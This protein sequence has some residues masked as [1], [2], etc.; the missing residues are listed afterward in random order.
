MAA[1]VTET[2]STTASSITGAFGQ[3]DEASNICRRDTLPTQF[4]QRGRLRR[5]RK[6]MPRRVLD[7]PVMPVG[8]LWNTEQLLQQQVH[9]GRPEQV[10][11]PHHVG[12]AL[13][14]VVD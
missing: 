11:A 10:P 2:F 1:D 3:S 7:Q 5:F 4:A 13:Q 12:D 8:R 6:L 14:G 9:A